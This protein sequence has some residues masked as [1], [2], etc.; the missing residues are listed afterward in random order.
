MINLKITLVLL[1]LTGCKPAVVQLQEIKEKEYEL[2]KDKSEILEA[3]YDSLLSITN[4][5]IGLANS[6]QRQR[7]SVFALLTIY[8]YMYEKDK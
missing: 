5:A 8:K 6:A 1:L 4:Q 7:D 2:Y 3:Q